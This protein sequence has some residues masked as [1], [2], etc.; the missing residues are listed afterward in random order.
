MSRIPRSYIKTSIFHI[1]TQ[2][3]NKSYIFD[4]PQD[5]KYYISLMYKLSCE[6]GA[7]II[8]YCVM[9]N[10]VHILL[11][12]ESISELSKYMQRL[13]SKY[14]QYYNKKYNRIGYVF[15]DRYKSEG[16]YSEKQLYNC[17]RYIYNN[18]VKAGIC[19]TPEQYSYSNYK[20]IVGEIDEEYIFIDIKEDADEVCIRE[21]NKFLI[22]KNITLRMLKKDRPRSKELI[23]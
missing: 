20:K 22:E 4:N 2:G 10:H 15:R 8:A 9:N 17:I 6:H 19:N 11:E 3:L 1:M 14:A 5:K 12:N 13:N 16:I 18:P 23:M 21:I 7:S